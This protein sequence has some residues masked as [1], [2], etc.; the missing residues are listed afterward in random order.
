MTIQTINIGAAP[1]DDTGDD[2]R[3]A[4]DKINDNFAICYTED[5]LNVN[6]FGGDAPAS[7]VIASGFANSTTGVILEL[8]TDSKTA[9]VSITVDGSFLVRTPSGFVVQTGVTSGNIGLS[10]LSSNKLALIDVTGMSGLTI[11]SPYYLRKESS[12]SKITV[13]Y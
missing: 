7:S 2:P 1:N 5:N 8:H 3:T 13:N 12:G 10:G 6:V 9:P 11:N 4:G